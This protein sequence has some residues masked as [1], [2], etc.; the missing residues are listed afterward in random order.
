MPNLTID[1]DVDAFLAATDTAG[2]RTA[3]G[4]GSVNNTSD[5]GKPVS[6][7][8]QTALDLKAN[9]ASP[10]LT[11]TPTVPTASGGTNTTQ[12][13]S[14]AF[15]TS[16]V[17]A[18]VAGLLDDKGA[19]D[20]S[21]NPDYPSAL[22]GDCYRV[23]VAGKVGGASG[24]TVEVGDVVICSADNAGGSQ[25]SVGTSWYVVQ[26][27]LS[28]AVLASNNLSDLSNVSTARTNLGLGNLDNTSDTNKPVS[29]AQQTAIDLAA[30]APFALV[31]DA[32]TARTLALTD[33]KKYIRCTSSSSVSVTVPPQAS[34][35]WLADTEIVIERAGTG[36]LTIV[37]G[38]G[39]TLVT[40]RTLVAGVRYSA[41][42]LK[43]IA[44]DSWVVGG[45]TV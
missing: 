8:Q 30:A 25:A 45:A 44:S 24:G 4:L 16:A 17:N 29:T 26:A 31:T 34:V 41:V 15:V 18:A 13:A 14:T 22:K 36:S 6:T 12:I 38:A 21:A 7:A 27:N 20:C 42:T 40:P 5:A 32:T 1:A 9:I 33:A 19:I 37:A 43:R 28:G 11:G 3:I 39:V 2:M 10:A 23:T 35:A